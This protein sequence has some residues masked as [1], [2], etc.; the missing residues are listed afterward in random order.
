MDAAVGKQ[1]QFIQLHKITEEDFANVHPTSR[2]MACPCNRLS[3]SAGQITLP[4]STLIDKKG[5]HLQ[6][7]SK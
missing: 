4:R 7:A 1:G 3:N 6:E 5:G 2:T